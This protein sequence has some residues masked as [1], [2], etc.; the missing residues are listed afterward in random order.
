MIHENSILN[1]LDIKTIHAVSKVLPKPGSNCLTPKF[2]GFHADIAKTHC[3]D[4]IML[5][6]AI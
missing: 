4:F 6:P 3:S 5:K 1:Q 2:S